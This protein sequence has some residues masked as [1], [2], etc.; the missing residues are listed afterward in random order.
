M[1]LKKLLLTAAAAAV[2]TTTG[3]G[4][5]MADDRHDR[6]RGHEM[7]RRGDRHD[8]DRTRDRDW[9][10]DRDWR[11]D[12]SW[13]GDHDRYWRPEFRG[14]FVARDR[15]FFEL[16]RHHYNRFLG[17]PMWFHGRYVVR[18]YDRGGNIVFIEVN[19]YTGGFVG[20]IS[21]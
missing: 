21:F 12:T 13:R 19:P 11:G 17:D 9:H 7:D 6:D 10:G 18:S 5:A 2:L 14:G 8:G 16:R 3:A 1:N 4:M 15:V 20:E